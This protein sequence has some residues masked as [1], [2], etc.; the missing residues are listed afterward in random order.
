LI[1]GVAASSQLFSLRFHQ[2]GWL[3]GTTGLNL[4][5]LCATETAVAADVCRRNDTPM[6]KK[7]KRWVTSLLLFGLC[8]DLKTG[9]SAAPEQTQNLTKR[10]QFVRDLFW[11][12]GNPEMTKPGTQTLA[13]FAQASPV[14]R[15]QLLGA[16]NI[17]MAGFGLPDDEQEADRL[18]RQV[19]G[20]KRV[21]WEISADG[22][23]GPPFVYERRM[24]VL[25]RLA[26]KYPQIE[27]VLLDDMS[28]V[29]INKGFKPEHI[30]H[31]RTLLPGEYRRIKIWGVV[32]TMSFNRPQMNDYIRELDVIL[33]AEWHAKR[34]VNLEQNVDRLRRLFPGKPIVLGLY[35]YDYGGGRRMPMD[36]LKRQFDI[37][38]K[39]AHAGA[40]EGIEMTTINND[41]EVV[42]WTA[43]WIRRVGDQRIGARDASPSE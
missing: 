7:W 41:P 13:T 35:L 26:D 37:A 29:S 2:I 28:T 23:G 34:V 4:T 36:L 10:P 43:D 31:I 27:G 32:Y 8:V 11:A 22:K 12:W 1:H 20:L 6:K 14:R 15:A 21:V 33:M 24:G 17:F 3:A 40:I 5:Q 16:P 39:L 18:T 38:L 19:L 25:R 42:Q 9:Q 30:R